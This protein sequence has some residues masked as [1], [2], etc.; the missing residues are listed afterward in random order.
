[1]R[2]ELG[3][4]RGAMTTMSATMV[5]EEGKAFERALN[6]ADASGPLDGRARPQRDSDRFVRVVHRV[7]AAVRDLEGVPSPEP[8]AEDRLF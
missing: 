7:L 6:H 8:G 4:T 2:L 1:M 5:T 3:D